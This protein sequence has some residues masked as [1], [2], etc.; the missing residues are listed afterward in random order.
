MPGASRAGTSAPVRGPEATGLVAEQLSALLEHQADD[1]HIVF[2]LEADATIPAEY[3]LMCHFLDRIDRD[4]ER[5]LAGY[6]RNGQSDDGSWP[7]FHG[8]AGNISATVKAYWALKLAGEDMDAPPMARARAW[9]LANGGAARANVFT[10][11]A[12]ALFGHVPWRAV[13]AMPVEALLLPRRAPFHISKISYWSRTV[14]V[15]LLVLYS[16]K[17]RAANPTGLGIE[18]LFVV[19]ADREPRY[20]RNP[21]GSPMGAVFLRL[22]AFLR[23]VEALSP[24]HLKRRGL[25]RAEDFVLARLNG[26]DG[27]GA[28]FPA[29]VN[30][31][32]MF[33]ALGYPDDDPR[34]RQALAA[35]DRLITERDDGAYA[36]P[37]FSPVWDTALACH[38]LMEGGADRARVEQSL[39]WLAARQILDHRGDWAWQRP[40]LRP[41]GWAFQYENPDYP[42]VDDTAVV[43]MAMH[44]ADPDRYRE[45]IARGVE[46]LAGMQSKSGGWGAFD[47]DNEHTYLNAIPFADH[48]A[49]LDPPTA[50]VS[51]RCVGCL[52]QIDRLRFGHGI[53]RGIAFLRRAQKPDGSWFGRWGANH[54]YGTWSVLCALRGAGL[55]PG[56]PAVARGVEWLLRMQHADGGWGEGL[57]SYEPG[58]DGLD[59]PSTASQTAWAVLGLMAAGCEE[60]SAVRAGLDWLERAPRDGARWRE[61]QYTGVGFPRVFYLKYHGYPAIFPLWALAR[62][63]RLANAND[64]DCHWGI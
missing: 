50:D 12:M 59:T 2:E 45:A 58:K 26:E 54:V 38:A 63:D 23:R 17:A 36:Q 47:A 7:L 8:G 48:G 44:R 24:R 25:R 14:M 37:C 11:I 53:E 22:D 30:A 62:A 35:V 9:V 5:R 61:A 29:M 32:L 46:W 52:A 10:R 56:D 51:A 28:I 57:E 20:N 60:S 1:G 19:P 39:D 34:F 49:L 55:D 4:R 43:L 3:I 21:T 31:V 64:P 27:L 41:G 6:L 16:L 42:D 15:P 13:P 18:E 40:G 33:R